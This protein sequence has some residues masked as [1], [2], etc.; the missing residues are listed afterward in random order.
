[1]RHRIVN[2]FPERE[3]QLSP[4]LSPRLGLDQS[5]LTGLCGKEPIAA[6]QKPRER[7]KLLLILSF[8]Y[9]NIVVVRF[10]HVQNFM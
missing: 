3:H 2:L 9:N 7:E 1:M 5:D 8:I 10:L 6:V 4:N